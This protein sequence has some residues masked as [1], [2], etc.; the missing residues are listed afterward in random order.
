[1]SFF[2]RREEVGQPNT[3]PGV[4]VPWEHTL[5]GWPQSSQKYVHSTPSDPQGAPK[6]GSAAGQPAVVKGGGQFQVGAPA[7]QDKSLVG[8]QLVQRHGFP[9]A[10]THVVS[11][12]QGARTVSM[13][14][15]PIACSGV[16]NVAFGN[17]TC[18]CVDEQAACVRHLSPRG[19]SPQLHERP[20][21]VQ[22]AP[23]A[24]GCPG[25]GETVAPPLPTP[26]LPPV[27]PAAAPKPAA[28]S[29]VAGFNEMPPH[30]ANI[31]ARISETPSEVKLRI[32]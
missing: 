29:D 26:P 23:S 28:P 25:Q 18:H 17:V 20:S 5:F 8:A 3:C 1:M 15:A 30:S 24:G 21:F 4:Q 11:I 6:F 13:G 22:A 14:Q 7:P 32:L 27:P 16:Q 2:T 10:F 19:S 31:A 9:S 12:A